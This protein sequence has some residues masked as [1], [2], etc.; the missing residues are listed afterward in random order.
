MCVVL[1]LFHK[2]TK[3]SNFNPCWHYNL[4]QTPLKLKLHFCQFSFPFLS[5]VTWMRALT[6]VKRTELFYR[7]LSLL[8]TLPPPHC[9]SVQ[10][11]CLISDK[12]IPSSNPLTHPKL[13]TCY[14]FSP[15]CSPIGWLVFKKLSSV[16]RSVQS[17]PNRFMT[18]P[19]HRWAVSLIQRVPCCIS[20][21]SQTCP[22]SVIGG[23]LTE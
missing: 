10:P 9:P 7:P 6:R 23:S 16:G 2:W 12:S 20:A 4:T 14:C 19:V 3:I 15:S 21:W 8:H 11:L 17:K 1:S 22:K 18:C 5:L 13:Q